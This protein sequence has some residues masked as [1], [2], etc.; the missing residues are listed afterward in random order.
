MSD[1]GGCVNHR[2]KRH[3]SARLGQL[4]EKKRGEKCS[5]ALV[6][7][8]ILQAQPIQRSRSNR[9]TP[10]DFGGAK[11]KNSYGFL[12]KGKRGGVEKKN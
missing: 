1:S 6:R 10:F 5:Q 4:K 7:G 3:I 11:G 2:R 12:S 8:G 9:P